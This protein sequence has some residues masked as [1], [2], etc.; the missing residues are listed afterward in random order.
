MVEQLS[1]QESP[2]SELA[3]LD[4]EKRR[5]ECE[6]LRAEIAETS[7]T[8]WKRAGYIGS[9]TPILI[10]LVGLLSA[11]ATGFFDAQRAT[12][13]SEI[14]SLK[15]QEEK[16]QNRN[17]ELVSANAGIQDK[18]DKAYIS[19]KLASAD[20]VYALGHMRGMGPSISDGDRKKIEA[21][22]EKIPVDVS[23][24]VRTL[25]AKNELAE[26]IVPITE[27]ELEGFSERLQAIPA[28][29]WVIEL[30]P[31]GGPIPALRAP[32]GRIYNPADGKFYDKLENLENY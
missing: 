15:Q 9:A 17:S 19:L 18:I 27:K 26:I 31:I 16:L 14:E 11:W 10:A 12:L 30:Q 23:E 4:I 22:F 32:D 28:S 1:K 3:L 2:S 21:I 7:L 5:L 24:L 8:W 20:A 6:K 13:K 29:E 25:L